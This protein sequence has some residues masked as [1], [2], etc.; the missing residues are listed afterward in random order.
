MTRKRQHSP[1]LRQSRS[2]KSPRRES[3]QA[4]WRAFC[5]MYIDHKLSCLGQGPHGSYLVESW[6]TILSIVPPHPAS[7]CYFIYSSIGFSDFDGYSIAAVGGPRLWQ[8]FM[9]E[10][11]SHSGVGKW[12]ELMSNIHTSPFSYFTDYYVFPSSSPPNSSFFLTTSKKKKE[13]KQQQKAEKNGSA[14]YQF[15]CRVHNL[16]E[17][18]KT[19]PRL[20]SESIIQ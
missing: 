8:P 10:R 16:M 2:Y 20:T 12:V 3:T 13:K 14:A 6:H 15:G 18:F 9:Y 7:L 17:S 1:I 19:E 11:N 5:C 4:R